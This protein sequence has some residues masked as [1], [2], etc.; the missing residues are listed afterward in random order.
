MKKNHLQNQFSLLFYQL[1]DNFL[2]N[3]FAML[4]II[5]KYSSFVMLINSLNSNAIAYYSGINDLPIYIFTITLT[6]LILTSL[7]LGIRFPLNNKLY[8][9][10]FII[11]FLSLILT[12]LWTS[13]KNIIICIGPLASFFTLLYLDRKDLKSITW[14]FL[15]LNLP[16]AIYEY[17]S[18][19]YLYDFTG[20]IYGNE[21]KIVA[22]EDLMRSKG[23][24][25]SCL[26]LGYFAM[27]SSFIFNNDIKI[28]SVSLIL[29]LLGGSRQPLV[30]V[31]FVLLVYL[32]THF[33]SKN[34]ILTTLIGF[35]IIA[36]SIMFLQQQSI[37]RILMTADF[38]NDSSNEFRIIFWLFGINTYLFEYSFLQ[39]ALGNMGYFQE[40]IGYNAESA[41]LTL[42]L[43][44]G[45]IITFFYV[46]LFAYLAIKLFI[47]KQYKKIALL[48]LIFISMGTVP[49]IFNLNQNMYFWIF[50]LFIIDN[51]NLQN[52]VNSNFEICPKNSVSKT[53]NVSLMLS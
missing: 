37:E 42:L 9:I 10:I 35:I 44:T 51:N 24:F 49:L 27:F 50:I 3:S 23:L 26:G 41:W 14:I 20:N 18:F 8:I 32:M 30:M 12:P 19:S 43:D 11:I 25:A 45:F 15:T 36:L 21:V 13:Y 53:D 33:T 29:C 39:Q 6:F 46:I 28:I 7:K 22:Y 1:S 5:G 40:K 34:L 2:Y 38:K 4:K 31:S 16:I 47:I 17:F 48:G 52:I